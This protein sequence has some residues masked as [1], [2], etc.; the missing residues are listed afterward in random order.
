MGLSEI[1]I[2]VAFLSFGGW[3]LIKPILDKWIIQNNR[4]IRLLVRKDRNFPLRE[5]LAGSSFQTLKVRRI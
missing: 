3:S 4:K 5:N 1:D 2:A